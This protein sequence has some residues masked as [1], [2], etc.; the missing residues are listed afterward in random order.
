[1]RVVK[2]PL[3]SAIAD[4]TD[5]GIALCLRVHRS[6]VAGGLMANGDIKLLDHKQLK[7]PRLEAVRV[8][9]ESLQ[10]IETRRVVAS[11]VDSGGESLDAGLAVGQVVAGPQQSKLG[12]SRR[13]LC[14]IGSA[15]QV[16]AINQLTRTIGIRLGI[17]SQRQSLVQA[18][19]NPIRIAVPPQTLQRHADR[20]QTSIHV[21]AGHSGVI[22]VVVPLVIIHGGPNLLRVGLVGVDV[23]HPSE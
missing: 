14:S 4:A 22:H 8:A 15:S 1:L 5:E 20:R 3:E 10:R 9:Q 17:F 7:R 19:S 16:R 21:H 6:Y 18:D 2:L 23:D 11:G 13:K 12:L